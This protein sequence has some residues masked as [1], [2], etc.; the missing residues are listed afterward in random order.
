MRPVTADFDAEFARAADLLEAGK[1]REAEQVLS[2]IR[3]QSGQPAWEARAAFLLASDEA[4]RGAF[5]AAAE[6][7][8][9][10]PAGA[11]GLEPY[12]RERRA[13]ALASAGRRAEALKEWRLAFE[14]EEPFA[15]RVKVGLDLAR[16]LEK[17]KRRGQALEVLAKAAAIASRAEISPLSIERIR[18]GLAEKDRKA[19]REAARALLLLSPSADTA[20]ATPAYVR[21]EMRREEE[22]LS[23]AE[24]ASRGRALAAAGDARRAAKLLSRDPPGSWPENEHGRNFLAL[25]RAEAAL[26]HSA[27]A[28]AAAARVPDGTPE[29]FE[30]RLLENDLL[31][32]SLRKEEASMPPADDPRLASLRRA[33][34]RIAVDSAARTVRNAARERLL[35]LAA[36]A[37]DFE[38]GLEH[39]RALTSENRGTVAGFEPLWRLAWERYRAGDFAEARR[40]FEALG[41]LYE[42]IWRDRRV[43][44]WRA[45]CLER[46]GRAEESAPLYRSLAASDPP[47]V[48]AL[49]ARRR[50][51]GFEAPKLS[52]L[53]DPSTATAQYRRTDELL[54]LRMFEE[55]AAEARSLEPSRGREL[56]LAEA[57]F[58]LGRFSSAALAVKRA[59]PEI[60]TAQEGRVPDGW[61]R[62]HY[63]VEEGG[64]LPA[65]AKEFR[66]DPSLLRGLVR[67][68]SVFD[69]EAKS[70]AGA[71]GLTQ[72]MPATARVLA[73]S[74]LRVRYRRAFLYDPGVNARLGAAYL[75]QMLDRFGGS[76][77]AALAAYN[78][79]PTRMARVL[80]ENSG[81]TE[82]EILESHPA[83]ETREYV[84]RVLLYAESYRA[85]YPG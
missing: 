2:E 73:R 42:D 15:I 6:R 25:A 24:R 41:S 63:P 19:V 58:A 8:R 44:Y 12:R 71:L 32:A 72:L 54:R 46:E 65:R 59:F 52:P 4:R 34:H 31:L 18:M 22:R 1:R 55:A 21:R 50:V 78:G 40:R 20:K 60:G 49:F 48:Y 35:L 28:R 16:G 30:A 74:V 84:R 13:R 68:E 38:E 70:R 69:A 23:P 61:R 51:S 14:T 83:S 82:D 66:L 11:I 37:K 36:E 57:E 9:L 76:P 80:R 7:L 17:A 26:G 79:G 64:F 39:A 3:R 5:A 29:S 47:D 56:R 45:R 53:P 62:F 33:L 43:T 27:S 85:L 81:L 67:Q 10:A 77:I 75:R